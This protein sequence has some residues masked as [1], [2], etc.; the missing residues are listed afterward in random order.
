MRIFL[1][2]A[3]NLVVV[4]GFG[5]GGDGGGG[6]GC[7]GGGVLESQALPNFGLGWA[8]KMRVNETFI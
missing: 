5:D 7:G 3:D 2:S 8:V 1:I 4:V 6:G